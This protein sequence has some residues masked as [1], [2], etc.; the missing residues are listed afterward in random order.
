MRSKSFKKAQLKI[1]AHTRDVNV[2]DWS[3]VAT[4]LVVTGADDCAVKV[5]DLRM[6]G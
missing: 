5:W 6:I 3:S 1:K 2:C 4:H